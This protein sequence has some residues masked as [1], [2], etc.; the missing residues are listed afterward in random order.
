M[1]LLDTLEHS[2][3]RRLKKTVS[4]IPCD[5]YKNG[6]LLGLMVGPFIFSGALFIPLLGAILSSSAIILTLVYT[7]SNRSIILLLSFLI[8]STISTCIVGAFCTHYIERSII[9]I[10]VIIA[11]STAVLIAYN[12]IV[13][14][15][16]CNR[17]E[18]AREVSLNNTK[19]L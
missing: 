16:L 12:L 4:T 6:F 19:S 2:Q 10:Y 5:S 9:L 8:G 18:R 7:Y 1:S 14:G 15:L 3:R 11:L 17:Y 13:A